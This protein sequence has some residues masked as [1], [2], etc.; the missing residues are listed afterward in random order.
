M[1]DCL[2]VRILSYG[3]FPIS[4]VRLQKEA[5][6]DAA[7]LFAEVREVLGERIVKTRV[8]G[9]GSPGWVMNDLAEQGEIDL[10]VVGSP[11]RGALGRIFLGSVAMSLLPFAS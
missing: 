11:H 4:F 2:V 9:G 5:A 1:A 8:F 3:P 7:P 10:I 6:G